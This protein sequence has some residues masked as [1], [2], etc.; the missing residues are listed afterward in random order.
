MSLGSE[1]DWEREALQLRPRIARPRAGE[2]EGD[3][4]PFTLTSFGEEDFFELAYGDAARFLVDGGAKRLWGTCLAPLTLE[5]LG[6][7]LLGPVLG[8]VLRRRGAIALHASSVCLSGQAVVLCGPSESGKSTT[9]AALALRGVPVIAEDISPLSES[10]GWLYVEPGYPRVCL[11]PDTV[12]SLFGAENSL[13]L[14]TP[15]W[16]K[17][18]LALDGVSARFESLARPLGAVYLL[19]PRVDETNAPRIEDL[20]GRDALLELVQNTYMNWLLDRSRRA[21]ELDAL[22]KLVTEV[23]VR[24]IVPHSDPV[25]LGALCDLILKDA[26]HLLGRQVLAAGSGR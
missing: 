1:P 17:C 3:D 11:W 7:Y 25:R 18:F 19:G 16:E 9:A 26:E 23:P 21:A 13:P 12:K 2:P 22:S 5:D 10:D 8:F 6:T 4:S 15:T 20:G 14:L 24:R